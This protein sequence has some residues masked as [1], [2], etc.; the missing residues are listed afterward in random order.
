MFSNLNKNEF[1]KRVLFVGIPDMAYICLDGLR[2]AGANIV[3]VIGPKK[4]HATYESFKNFVYRSNL[5]F[6][7]FDKLTDEDFIK[8][9]RELKADIAVVCSFNYRVPKVL[10]ES[11][12]DGFIN[13][14]PSFLPEYRGPNPYSAVIRN[15]ESHTGVT[16]HFMDEDFDTGD[17]IHQKK[18]E[19]SS[20]ETMGTLFN[21]LN[22][23]AFE[24][25]LE[26]LQKYENEELTSQK[27]PRGEFK[28]ASMFNE[29]DLYIDY[30]KSAEEI[31]CFIRSLNP[32]ILARTNFRNTPAKILSAEFFSG[33]N[34]SEHP[35][36]TIVKIADN[37]IY[38]ATGEGLLTPTS[39][40]YGSFFAGTV[41]EFIK[42]LDPK[43]GERFL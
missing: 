4:S 7:K 39:M 43:V 40:Q 24:M 11:V 13:V 1:K 17:I 27:Q 22:L 16:L 12:K 8:H 32:F 9:V 21:R 30:K 6:I 20:I 36:G 31:E 23:L 38:I 3:G 2:A 10:L 18:L 41:K 42:I 29:D 34:S 33:D 19:L 15:K 26:T 5:N 37:K 25:L 28:K 35:H 14:H